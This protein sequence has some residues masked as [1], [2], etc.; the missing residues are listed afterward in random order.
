MHHPRIV[1]H[2]LGQR[3]YMETLILQQ[4]IQNDLKTAQLLKD[5]ENKIIP[6]TKTVHKN[7][8]LLVEHSP[9]VYTMGKRDTKHDFLKDQQSLQNQYKQKGIDVDFVK[10]NRGGAVTWH[11]PGQL[12]GYPILNLTDFNKSVKWY[13]E[14]IEQVLMKTL[15][16]LH[17]NSHTTSDVGVW[18]E[19]ERKVAA[20]GVAVSRWITMHGFAL[21]VC[22]DL[23]YYDAIVPCGLKDKQVTTIEKELN[24]MRMLSSN[25]S[26]LSPSTEHK[27]SVQDVIPLLVDSFGEVFNAKM[28]YEQLH[29]EEEHQR[30]QQ[31][32][33]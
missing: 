12:V 25:N 16:K 24:R 32:Q 8:L 18:I 7:V 3:R 2:N 6:L 10:T 9:P 15:S 28:E 27:I 5:T 23:S 29:Q 21:N 26:I 1:V 22:N 30:E 31:S 14:S 13:V 33:Q 19:N 17:I 4:Q 20:I 11:G